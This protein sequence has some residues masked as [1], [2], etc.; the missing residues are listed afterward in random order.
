MPSKWLWQQLKHDP[1]IY[2][3]DKELLQP[4][5]V[6]FQGIEVQSR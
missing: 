1:D 3:G 5:L 2:S 6:L 4:R